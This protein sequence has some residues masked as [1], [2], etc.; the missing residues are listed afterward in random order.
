MDL[1]SKPA[2]LSVMAVCGIACHH[3]IEGGLCCSMLDTLA[4]LVER[5]TWHENN[6][7]ELSKRQVVA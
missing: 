5:M 1:A 4:A 7:W 2:L 6:T 3:F